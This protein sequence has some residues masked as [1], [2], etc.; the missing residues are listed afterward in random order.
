MANARNY[1]NL[2]N[3]YQPEV[4]SS[5]YY[6]CHHQGDPSNGLP[7]DSAR[8]GSVQLQ[9]ATTCD[10]PTFSQSSGSTSSQA[11]GNPIFSV[12]RSGFKTARVKAN[13]AGEETPLSPSSC[14]LGSQMLT[15]PDF[16]GSVMTGIPWDPAMADKDSA[17]YLRTADRVSTTI[18][19]VYR[20]SNLSKLVSHSRATSLSP[21][22]HR[23]G[24]ITVAFELFLCDSHGM[25]D[26]S[27]ANQ[28]RTALTRPLVNA[29]QAGL[30]EL[31]TRGNKTLFAANIIKS[32]FEL[33][34]VNVA[35]L[36]TASAATTISK[37][38]PTTT[39]TPSTTMSTKKAS[40]PA[41]TTLKMTT[42]TTTPSSAATT[43]SKTTPTTTTTPSTTMSTKKASTPAST[44]LKMTTTTTTPSSAATTISK[45]TPTT[46]TTLSTTMSTKKASTPASTT[47]K[48]TTTTT[49]PSSTPDTIT[50]TPSTAT[51]PPRTTT[52]T[53]SEEVTTSEETVP[54]CGVVRETPSARIVG[55]SVAKRGAYPWLVS[56]TI[57]DR[58]PNCGG[59]I[60][61]TLHVITNAYCLDDLPDAFH[62]DGHTLD[63][64][65][66]AYMETTFDLLKHRQTVSVN[67]IYKH[68]GYNRYSDRYVNEIAVL[69]LSR[70]LTFD[71][72]VSP[73]CLPDA[74]ST[75]P[76]RCTVAGW[77]ATA[78]GPDFSQSGHGSGIFTNELQ[79]VTL[80]AYNSSQC[81]LTFPDFKSYNNNSIDYY[82]TEGVMCAANGTHGGQDACTRDEGSPLVCLERDTLS[83]RERYTQFG[84][85]SWGD[86]WCGKPG[87][88]GLYT[89]LPYFRKWLD[90]V[91]FPALASSSMSST[92]LKMTTTTTTLSKTPETVTTTPSSTAWTRPRTTTRIP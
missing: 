64:L 15:D 35:T 29:F 71:S 81:R 84:I 16:H 58:P 90:D 74:N 36:T 3:D 31:M 83:N 59:S 12:T 38:T 65:A 67:A 73:V 80:W 69:R 21:T 13:T 6:S 87:S 45:T 1:Q 61:D 39:T 54:V 72:Y 33:R 56:L 25:G 30:D 19:E 4:A 49:T 17:A 44:T 11:D 91:A 51:T 26:P 7:E 34:P 60:I 37:T 92:T 89:Y 24:T 27:T 42:T 28:L 76:A 77:G 79:E 53:P 57:N 9:L 63:I 68:E 78:T 55:G 52:R 10:E 62:Q 43:I 88:P 18:A 40:T 70:P 20:A 82:L 32:S 50:T 8:P 5:A 47:L 2:A 48:M 23:E 22:Q 46:T 75:L 85:V 66:G 14:T 86:D 41:S